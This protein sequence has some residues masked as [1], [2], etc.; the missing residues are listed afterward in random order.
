MLLNNILKVIEKETASGSNQV[1][2][3]LD[4]NYRIELDTIITELQKIGYKCGFNAGVSKIDIIV[5]L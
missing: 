4:S 5:K 1:H 3:S 2:F